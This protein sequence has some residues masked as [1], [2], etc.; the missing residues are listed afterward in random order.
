MRVGRTCRV[1]SSDHRTRDDVPNLRGKFRGARGV[2]GMPH[3]RKP[4]SGI[5][6][7]KGGFDVLGGELRVAGEKFL[8]VT[9]CVEQPHNRRDRDASATDAW[10]ATHDVW[11]GDDAIFG[12]G[13]SLGR[14]PISYYDCC[15][16]VHD[17]ARKHGFSDDDIVLAGTEFLIAYALDE[18]PP[19][20]EL[21]L[22]FDSS[23]RLLEII[24]LLLEDGTELA[25]HAMK[26]RT[27]YFDLLP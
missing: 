23:G 10:H 2:Q 13:S 24:V 18:G 4:I 20:K 12:H 21:R 1:A 5:L 9:A 26:C 16:D 15:V 11:V 7:G 22:G 25:I 27:K 14:E 6:E 3:R 19:S 8:T 17:S